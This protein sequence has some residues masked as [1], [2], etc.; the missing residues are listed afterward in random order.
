MSGQ[1]FTVTITG[2][3]GHGYQLQRADTLTGPWTTVGNNQP[4]TGAMLAFTD[5]GG[6]TGTQK[7]YRISVAP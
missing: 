3:A 7:F 5:N 1:S 2:Y 6:A 4:G